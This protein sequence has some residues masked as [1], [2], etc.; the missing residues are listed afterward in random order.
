LEVKQIFNHFVRGGKERMEV[1]EG[2]TLILDPYDD[3]FMTIEAVDARD[4]AFG[5]AVRA[6]HA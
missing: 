5:I 4:V 3:N 2:C 6:H 1:R